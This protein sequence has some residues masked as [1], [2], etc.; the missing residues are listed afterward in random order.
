MA[1]RILIIAGEASGDMHAAKLITQVQEKNQDITFFGIGGSKM[2]AAGAEILI[3]SKQLSVLGIVEV[4]PRL[5]KIYTA[6]QTIKSQLK[7]SRPDLVI[8]IDFSGFNLKVARAAKDL[9]IKVLY[10]ISPQVWASR[11]GRV[12]KIKKY[13]DQM[14][15]IFPFEVD[16]YR[17]LHVPVKLVRHP[18]LDDAHSEYT[19]EAAHNLLGLKAQ[20]KTVGILPGSRSGEIKNLLPTLLATAK[21]LKQENPNLQFVLPLASTIKETDIASYLAKI[22]VPVRVVDQNIYDVLRACDAVMVA[23][24]T[25]TL[26]VALM[27]I[28]MAI[29]YRLSP[30][31]YAI[32]KRIVKLSCIGLCNIVAGKKIVNEYIQDEV[33]VEN[34]AAEINK[35]LHDEIYAQKIKQEL[36]SIRNKLEDKQNENLIADIILKILN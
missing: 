2:R 13:V 35:I 18:L 22:D 32:G 9:G 5:W 34:L 21:K 31:T 29:V 1:K 4:L 15:V 26:Q 16:F 24:G 3:D 19:Q 33:N 10:Y 12:E 28:P 27:H 8:L 14:A 36:V 30:I 6:L 20:K 11:P 23:S 7:N 17:K 25:A